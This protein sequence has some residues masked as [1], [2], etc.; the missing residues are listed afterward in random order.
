MILSVVMAW[1][2]RMGSAPLGDCRTVQ[3]AGGDLLFA[4]SPM[5]HHSWHIAVGGV[6]RTGLGMSVG[7]A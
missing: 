2:L 6:L 7:N 4:G 1:G 3:H 5:T